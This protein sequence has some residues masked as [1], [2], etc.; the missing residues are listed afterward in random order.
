M[1]IGM[2]VLSAMVLGAAL[3]G[4][5]QAPTRG[6]TGTQV[7]ST[8]NPAA[9]DEPL[10]C[11]IVG[12]YSVWYAYTPGANGVAIFDTYGSTCNTT[13]GAYVGNPYQMSSLVSVACD[14]DSGPGESG[15]IRFAVTGGVTYYLKVAGYGAA[16]G[17]T[18]LNWLCGP[19]VRPALEVRHSGSA[20][21]VA[22]PALSTNRLMTSTGGGWEV[23]SPVPR[24]RDGL[25]V[26]LVNASGGLRYYALGWTV[27]LG[28]ADSDGYSWTPPPV[29]GSQSSVRYWVLGTNA[30]CSV[31][32]NGYNVV[33]GT[34]SPPE[35]SRVVV[36]GGATNV[37]PGSCTVR[38]V[39]AAPVPY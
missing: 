22:W 5:A 15:L 14:N 30:N 38:Y 23:V 3:N 19:A 6:F 17:Q 26:V 24:V 36:V 12:Q 21:K 28:L 29:P 31:E 4:L 27:G 20:V 11:G 32:A 18:T 9:V 39:T 2:S 25:N 8:L 35:G 10:N 34:G 13:L 16:S 1:K 33:V 7:F 37:I